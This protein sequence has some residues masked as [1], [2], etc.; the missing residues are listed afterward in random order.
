[1]SVASSKE[2][3]GMAAPIA[4][5]TSGASTSD[6]SQKKPTSHTV[7]GRQLQ[8]QVSPFSSSASMRRFASREGSK[9]S[10]MPASGSE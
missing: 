5:L 4:A 3:M 1:V 10:R 2:K 7:A 9:F 6:Q 8:V